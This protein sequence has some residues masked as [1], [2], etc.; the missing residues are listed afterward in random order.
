MARADSCVI[1]IELITTSSSSGSSLQQPHAVTF[2]HNGQTFVSSSNTVSR[3]APN[4]V[5]G[6]APEGDD[7]PPGITTREMECFTLLEVEEATT[8]RGRALRKG[9]ETWRNEVRVLQKRIDR[10]EQQSS[11]IKNEVYQL[12]GFFIVFQGVL[13]TAVA[14]AQ[15]LDCRNWSTVF[16]LSVLASAAAI[17]G[18]TQKLL[19][20][21][22]IQ[23]TI[24]EDEKH[25]RVL[26]KWIEKVRAKGLAFVD[27]VDS[28]Q[29]TP[30]ASNHFFTVYSVMVLLTLSLFAVTFGISFYFI[31]CK[32]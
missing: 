7:L 23:R 26:K 27:W 17:A 9:L 16:V 21:E 19:Q 31:L 13:Y 3:Q 8:R 4:S 11:Q 29:A 2:A 20:L 12:M 15:V 14:Q 28:S 24:K 1:D 22:D 32:E 5:G 30:D 6:H 25:P 10:K 18:V